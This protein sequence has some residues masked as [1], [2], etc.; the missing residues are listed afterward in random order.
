MNKPTK[1][2]LKLA[3]EIFKALESSG[4]PSRSI[5]QDN[6]NLWRQARSLYSQL[7][8]AQN[9]HNFKSDNL[10]EEC[11]CT[12]GEIR[13]NFNKSKEGES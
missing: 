7:E 8:T 1:E 6:C 12:R 4:T 11:R 5:I 13:D 2:L 9:F 10:C 3:D